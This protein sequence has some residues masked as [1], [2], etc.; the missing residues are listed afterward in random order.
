MKGL[1][2]AAVSFGVVLV[3]G[4]TLFFMAIGYKNK[5]VSLRNQITAKQRANEAS[6]DTCWKII[7]QQTQ[8]SDQY[9]DGFKEIYTGLMEGRHY[10]KG[11]G[12]MKFITEANPAFDIRLYEKVSNSIEAQRTSFLRDQTALLDLKREHDNT[13]DFMPSSWFLG[14]R[15]KIDVKIVTS[16]KS[17]E[18]FQTGKEEDIQ[19]FPK[20][21]QRAEK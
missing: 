20:K 17:Q 4:A 18:A 19:I 1:L 13:L 15:S 7:Q 12:L 3:L 21:D 16:G 14:G 6:F 11:G 8:V 5:E 2:V 9:K 10:E